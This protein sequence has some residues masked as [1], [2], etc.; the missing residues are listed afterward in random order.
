MSKRTLEYND[1]DSKL[2]LFKYAN[3]S[4]H[5]NVEMQDFKI[6]KNWLRKMPWNENYQAQIINI[7]C[8]FR[9]EF[10][11]PPKNGGVLNSSL[12]VQEILIE[13]KLLNSKFFR[14]GLC[15]WYS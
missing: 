12:N 5:K 2:L 9:L 4:E 8:T 6:I 13:L 15:L 1:R 7:S 14:G 11:T 3:E 10:S